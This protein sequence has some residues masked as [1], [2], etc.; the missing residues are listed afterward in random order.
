MGRKRFQSQVATGP[1]TVRTVADLAGVS[2]A[3]ASRV[4]NGLGGSPELSAR[5]KAAA[6]R[7]GYVPNAIAR[8]LQAQRTGLIGLAVADIGNP[9]YVQ[10][11]RA[12]EAEIADCGRQLL[13]H[14]TNANAA[15]ETEL[16]RGLARR[17]VDGMIMSPLRV[18]EAHLNALAKS[19][20]PVVVVG[21]LPDDAP[22]DNVRAD[23]IAGVRLAVDHLVDT[24]RRRIAMING[25]LDTVPGA[26]RDTGF[27]SALAA[28]GLAPADVEYGDFT[29]EAGLAAARRLLER[30]G[31]TGDRPDAIL[32]ANDLIAA[33]TLHALLAA[34][35]RVPHDVALVG[36]DNT[37]IT[38]L[39][40][41]RLTSVD[42]GAAERG[43]RAARLLLSRLDDGTIGPRRE[44]V[45]PTLVQR[46]ST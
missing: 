42:L 7:V 45:P 22:I 21:Q 17:Y 20:V 15:G 1:A 40:F 33:G 29:F 34:G 12:I 36:M 27:R 44:T 13:I 30:S 38:E 14:A 32:A 5:V 9:V 43:R 16:L 10:M 25:P 3:S 6:E 24:G 2:I 18:T 46:D 19:A 41:P 4:L 28:R 11:M 8:S 26:A 23:S 37:D 35:V 39:T 31:G